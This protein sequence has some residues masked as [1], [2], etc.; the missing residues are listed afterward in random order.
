VH[1]RI[2]ESGSAT[3]Y[4]NIKSDI[5]YN[6]GNWHFATVTSNGDEL[7]LYVDG[8]LNATAAVTVDMANLGSNLYIGQYGGGT[9][10]WNGCLD[11]VRI[12]D[13]AL[14]AEEILEL[15]EEGRSYKATAP[16][17]ADGATN[18]DPNT[19]LSWSPGKDAILHD[20]YLG[21]D[22]HDV[23]NANIGSPEYQ[24]N[25]DSNSWDPCGLE[26]LASYYW[27][28]DEIT[29]SNIYKG[30][31]WT[32]MTWLEAELTS[33]W[34]FDEGS[35]STA[36]DSAGT[37]DG[38]IY[39]DTAWVSGKV[40]PYALY[41]DGNGDGISVAHSAS[42]NLDGYTDS[43]SFSLWVNS[44]DPA[45]AS[46]GRLIQ[47]QGSVIKYYPVSFQLRDTYCDAY[48]YDGSHVPGVSFGNIWD[49]QWHHLVFAVDNFTDT[50]Y[51][52][53]DGDLV[54]SVTNTVTSTTAS[55]APITIAN[56]EG[57]SNPYKGK[58]DDVR[59]YDWTLSAGEVQQLYQ[60]GQ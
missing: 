40:G 17:P 29:D 38:I 54:D 60:A 19:V 44:S 46:S 5:A 15:Y 34:K 56:N 1:A 26:V 47:K 24:G 53:L 30:D 33:W 11:D 32:F 37:N 9:L 2:F 21:T 59:I 27:R 12:Y 13:R 48:I 58:I 4:N 31:V 10:Q 55:T 3:V 52:Y 57:A 49:G 45:G 50:L 16:N 39:G 43:Y 41:F 23:N 25:Q 8:V 22:F 20:V 35:G 36:Y 7:N 14:S 51:A 6:D 28:I 42:L 18:I